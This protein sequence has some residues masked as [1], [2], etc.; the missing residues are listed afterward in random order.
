MA[1]A[2]LEVGDLV[3]DSPNG[4]GTVTEITD[5]GYPKVN[6]IAVAWLERA[7]GNVFDPRGV[8]AKALAERSSKKGGAT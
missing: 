1:S 5:A 7:D 4:T 3:K 8:R 6:D 2:Y